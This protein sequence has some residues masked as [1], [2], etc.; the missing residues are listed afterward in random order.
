MPGFLSS[1]PN[2][3]PAPSPAG[4]LPS[5]WYEGEV[6]SLRREGGRGSQFGRRALWYSRYSITPLQ[7]YICV[8]ADF[9]ALKHSGALTALF[10]LLFYG[11]PLFKCFEQ[12][13]LL[14][15]VFFSCSDFSFNTFSLILSGYNIKKFLF[16]EWV[17]QK[18]DDFLIIILLKIRIFA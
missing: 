13:L 10:I 18:R 1:R 5:L 14:R 3:P 8:S 11:I 17:K 9:F 6:H 15:W 4:L 12:K 2:R 7:F 16:L